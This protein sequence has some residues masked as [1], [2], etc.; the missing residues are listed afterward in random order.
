MAK[1]DAEE[2]RARDLPIPADVAL[3]LRQLT[4]GAVEAGGITDIYGAAG[5]DRPDLSHLDEAFIQRMQQAST[6]TWP[7]RRCGAWSNRRCAA[8]PGTTWSGSRAFP[9]G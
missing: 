5:I 1:F 6:R 4:A 7:S 8:S 3:Y 9:T 2:R